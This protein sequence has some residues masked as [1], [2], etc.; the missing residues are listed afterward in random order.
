ML[1]NAAFASCLAGLVLGLIVGA[2]KEHTSRNMNGSPSAPPGITK[3]AT[4]DSNCIS[5]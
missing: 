5:L 3:L 2:I 1:T 4:K